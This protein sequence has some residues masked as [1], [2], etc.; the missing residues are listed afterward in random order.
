MTDWKSI[1]NGDATEWLL[2]ESNPSVRYFTLRWLLD[3]AEGDAEVVE[4]SHAIAR[5]SAVIK[6]LKK[7]KPEGYWGSDPRPH[8]GTRGYLLLLRWLGFRGN[9]AVNKAMDYRIEGCLMEDGAYGM[10]LK[11]RMVKLPC[12]GADMLRLMLWFGYEH[13]VR[14]RKLLDWLISI[15][16]DAGIWPCVSKLRPF[17]CMWAT[18]VVLRAYREL[19]KVWI[20]SEVEASRDQ[21]VEMFLNANLSQY[22]KGKP[23]PR[24][25]E[26]GFPLQWDSDVLEVLE[27]IAPHVHPDDER[28]Q[29]GL[30][31]VMSKQDNNGCWPCEKHPK[32]GRWM[33]R[34]VE[35]VEIG[36]PSKWVTLHAMRMLKSLYDK[37]N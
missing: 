26:F 24:W 7:Q 31:L 35:L 23:S 32:G 3:K 2:E 9:D 33:G 4:A 14:T 27:L 18:A 22:G 16:E 12:H 13:D 28:I 20:T 30:D 10:E 11:E 19:P 34:F 8:H 36:G 21:A 37:R 15:Q 25:F 1:L 5:S 17:S 6:I 29:E